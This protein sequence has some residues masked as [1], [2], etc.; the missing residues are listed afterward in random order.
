MEA[1]LQQGR[2]LALQIVGSSLLHGIG[3]EE[4]STSNMCIQHDPFGRLVALGDACGLWKGLQ[5]V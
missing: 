3:Q 4:N 5:G 1:A 2:R